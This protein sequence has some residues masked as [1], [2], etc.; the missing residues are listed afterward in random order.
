MATT[1][2]GHSAEVAPN[3]I[4]GGLHAKLAQAAVEVG[5]IPMLGQ[6]TGGAGNYSFH[7]A[8]DVFNAVRKA[9][10]ERG[11]TIVLNYLGHEVKEMNLSNGRVMRVAEV[12]YELVLTDSESGEQIHMPI[13]AAA[14][15]SGDKYMNKAQTIALKNAFKA[16][17]LIAEPG[18]DPDDEASPAD[19]EVAPTPKAAKAPSAPKPKP[20]AAAVQQGQSSFRLTDG[21][22]KGGNGG[23]ASEKQ[24]RLIRARLGK[25]LGIKDEVDQG[26]WVLN[27][28]GDTLENLNWKWMDVL[29]AEIEAH[30]AAPAPPAPGVDEMARAA[31]AQQVLDDLTAFA[32]GQ[33]APDPGGAVMD[34]MSTLGLADGMALVDANG[35]AHAAQ[36][37]EVRRKIT[38]SIANDD[39][40]F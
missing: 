29:L 7:R 9:F 12:D 28:T 23:A 3:P 15:D 35:D 10:S 39:I 21:E 27:V 1:T 18:D 14:Q 34:A 36:M 8:A 16:M 40:P 4:A 25:D 6:M 26:V 32:E 11:V 31:A 24:K 37:S 13:A 20:Q 33:G 22:P 30:A 2:N 17:F 38:E 19:H 5:T